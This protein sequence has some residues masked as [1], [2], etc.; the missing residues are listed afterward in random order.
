MDAQLNRWLEF[1]R[2]VVRRQRQV[3]TSVP[4]ARERST[5]I[6][7]GVGGDPTLDIDRRLEEILVDCLEDAP[8]AVAV[9][10]E[11]AGSIG[12]ADAT[13]LV[14]PLDGSFNAQRL[15]PAYA[16][17]VALAHGPRV[18]DVG[19]AYVFD[20]ATGDEF[21]AKRGHGAWLNGEPISAQRDQDGLAMVAFESVEYDPFL[22]AAVIEAIARQIGSFRSRVVGSTALALCYAAAGRVDAV[23]SSGE[24]RVID[25]AAAQLVAREAG[26]VVAC[27]GKHLDSIGFGLAREHRINAAPTEDQ[28]RSVVAALEKAMGFPNS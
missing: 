14:D 27:Q 9:V 1:F 11:E 6:G 26:L 5:V 13:L 16:F 4:T 24:C 21:V 2:E 25:F 12:D 8:E 7:R 3:L 28:L 17:S 15:F 20:L 18:G 19:L 23:V 22:L 10:S